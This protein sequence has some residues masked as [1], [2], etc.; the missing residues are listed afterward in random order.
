MG[1]EIAKASKVPSDKRKLPRKCIGL[2]ADIVV[3]FSML[4]SSLNFT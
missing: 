4:R 1:E 3:Q 2:I